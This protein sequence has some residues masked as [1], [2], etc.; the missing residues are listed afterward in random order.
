MERSFTF[1]FP[2]TLWRALQQSFTI[3]FQVVEDQL[4]VRAEE[5]IIAERVVKLLLNAHR[6]VSIPV[7]VNVDAA[8]PS[9]GQRLDHLVQWLA[10]D[11]AQPYIT[12]ASF[13]RAVAPAQMIAV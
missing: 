5:L 1:N 6:V 10:G 4:L 12:F 9:P 8:E 2:L 3:V 7:A 11:L 13:D